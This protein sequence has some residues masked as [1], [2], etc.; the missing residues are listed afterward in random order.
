MLEFALGWS[1]GWVPMRDDSTGD[2]DQ[3]RRDARAHV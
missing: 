3:H 1:E 2:D